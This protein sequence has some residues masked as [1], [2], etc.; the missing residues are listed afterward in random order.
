MATCVATDDGDEPYCRLNAPIGGLALPRLVGTTSDTGA[1]SIVTPTFFRRPAHSFVR[2][3]SVA[4]SQPPWVTADGIGGKSGP[5]RVCTWPPSWSAPICSEMPLLAL[6]AACTWARLAC[7]SLAEPLNRSVRNTPPS[8]YF[9]TV[10]CTLVGLVTGV[11]TMSSWPTWPTRPS[12]VRVAET[13]SPPGPTETV[14]GDGAGVPAVREPDAELDG[15][16]DGRNTTTAPTS[17]RTATRPSPTIHSQRPKRC[18]AA[19]RPRSSVTAPPHQG[20]RPP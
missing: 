15:D 14:T 2:V 19:C 7:R 18:S 17:T 1:R 5:C 6:A 12:A 3:V 4:W 13:Q 9:L 11:P 20:L 10:D 8:R 16:E